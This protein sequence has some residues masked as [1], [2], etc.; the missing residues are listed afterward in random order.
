MQYGKKYVVKINRQ[1]NKKTKKEKNKGSII[2][3]CH[4]F[5]F[6]LWRCWLMRWNVWRTKMM[7]RTTVQYTT[8]HQYYPITEHL[9]ECHL[10]ANYALLLLVWIQKG[11]WTQILIV[12][13]QKQRKI[14]TLSLLLATLSVARFSQQIQITPRNSWTLLL[15]SCPLKG[16]SPVPTGLVPL[17]WNVWDQERSTCWI[18]Q[19]RTDTVAV[20]F[21]IVFFC[22]VFDNFFA[23]VG[24]V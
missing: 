4:V 1:E 6:L 14:W 10:W 20:A 16:P 24:F 2:Y 15:L 19:V 5:F 12:K 11:S 17:L 13:S 23:S 22:I 7:T 3:L 9:D 8:H 21:S 18:I